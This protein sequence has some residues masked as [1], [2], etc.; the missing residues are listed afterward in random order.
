MAE[1][2]EFAEFVAARSPALL[3]TARLLTGD[4]AAAED[5]AA[6]RARHLL[7]TLVAHRGQPQAE[8]ASCVLV[9]TY[10]AKR[11]R[12]WNRERPTGAG[13]RRRAH[14]AAAG[15]PMAL[16]LARPD[17]ATAHLDIAV[18]VAFIALA[19]FILQRDPREGL[20]VASLAFIGH[21]LIDIAHRPGWLPPDLS[22]RW[23][24]AG[25]ATFN[26]YLAAWCFW[27]RRR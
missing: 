9:T 21:A 15:T 13:Q 5:A 10:L 27:A 19:G 16:A 4:W 20:I 12:F 26:V 17:M 8:R 25:C 24:T 22:P 23:Y 3:R 6:G 14:A 2:P 18:A 1:R 7:A 11:R